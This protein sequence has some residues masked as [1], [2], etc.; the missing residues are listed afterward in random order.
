M[1][2][3]NYARSTR[4]FSF[5][6]ALVTKTKNSLTRKAQ[7]LPKIHT[8]TII[9]LLAKNDADLLL[10]YSE[11]SSAFDTFQVVHK[12]ET[13]IST[14]FRKPNIEVIK[15][16]DHVFTLLESQSALM[17]LIY[18]WATN[19]QRSWLTVNSGN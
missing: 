13:G 14:L 7:S 9:Q 2:A 4:T 10:V 16:A 19:K 3:E 5:Y 18:Q 1:L 11:G 15:H 8:S 6:K 12:K 17:G